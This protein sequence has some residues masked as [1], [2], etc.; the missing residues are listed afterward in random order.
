MVVAE[1]APPV[2]QQAAVVHVRDQDVEAAVPIHVADGGAHVGN[3]LAVLA[4]GQPEEEGLLLEGAVPLVLV[5]VALHG[6]VGLVD[7][8]RGRRC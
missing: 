3:T 2:H 4:E 7:V 8:E 6:V 1:P 5:V